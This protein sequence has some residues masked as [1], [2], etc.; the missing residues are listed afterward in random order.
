M[1]DGANR[2]V[3]GLVIFSAAVA[4]LLGGCG[5]DSSSKDREVH[6]TTVG[7]QKSTSPL[8]STLENAGLR[9]VDRPIPGYEA[10]RGVV[11]VVEV[12][13]VPAESDSGAFVLEFSDAQQ[14]AGFVAHSPVVPVPT[15]QNS[16]Q[17][18]HFL[19]VGDGREI[20]VPSLD[21]VAAAIKG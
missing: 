20:N 15:P 7:V 4:L 17:V 10:K 18:G 13:P 14:I 16:R 11:R 5:G 1:G 21:K 12:L 8:A 2:R 6:K 19:V 3:Q 9:A